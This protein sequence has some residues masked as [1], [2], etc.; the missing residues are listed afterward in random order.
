M[1]NLHNQSI[2]DEVAKRIKRSDFVHQIKSYLKSKGL[3]AEEIE[4]YYLKGK[5]EMVTQKMAKLPARNK[6]IFGAA[7]MGI[8]VVIIVF[9]WLWPSSGV[10]KSGIPTIIGS[11][12]I[13]TFSFIVLL[14]HKSWD[15]EVIRAKYEK[16][17]ERDTLKPLAYA[18]IPAFISYFAFSACF[19]QGANNLLKET[20]VST[21][22]IVTNGFSNQTQNGSTTQITIEFKT[23]TG[24]LIEVIK[25]V[26]D[27][28]FDQ[29][30]LDQKIPVV[31]SSL[32]PY[33][34]KLLMDDA[35]IKEFAGVDN[36]D[37]HPKDLIEFFDV[38]A[39]KMTDELNKISFGW[40]PSIET[41]S[42]WTNSMRMEDLIIRPNSVEFLT[43][44]ALLSSYPRMLEKMG[45]KQISKDVSGGFPS[46]IEET[47]Y[48][49]SDYRVTLQTYL[50]QDVYASSALVSRK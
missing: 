29:Y 12:L 40:E 8:I 9:T 28:D 44:N 22:G 16:K 1:S 32:N 45:Y 27:R 42:A 23:N 36:R 37:I 7:L 10:L 25:D 2:I 50:G 47:V 38:S 17:K 43:T 49:A 6:L 46:I 30:Y 39:E 20:M 21:S 14:F 4:A 13:L 15:P 3:N 34:Y 35:S 48:A 5:E 26:D 11:A 31:Y 33:H 18:I 19:Q 24:K 41:E